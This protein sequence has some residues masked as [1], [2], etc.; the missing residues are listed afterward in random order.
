MLNA[1]LEEWKKITLDQNLFLLIESTKTKS[2]QKKKEFIL[3]NAP[4]ELLTTGWGL[5]E[6]TKEKRQK[7]KEN[8]SDVWIRLNETNKSVLK[9][10]YLIYKRRE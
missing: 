1:V 6:K 4:F 7:T 10:Y 3:K 5:L 9:R 2:L 8:E